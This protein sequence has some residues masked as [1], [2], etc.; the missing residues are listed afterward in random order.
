[1]LSIY[2]MVSYSWEYPNHPGGGPNVHGPEDTA[3][4]LSF[5]QEFRKDPVGKN[6]ILTAATYIAPFNGPDGSPLP[7]MSGFAKVLDWIVVMNYDIWGSWSPSVGPN[8][9]LDDTCAPSGFQHGSATSA[10][11]KWT[12]AG[13]PR[14]Q[15]VLGVPGYGHSFKVSKD[16]AYDKKAPG[17]LA[18][19]PPFQTASQPA[20]DSW[21]SG[22]FNMWGLVRNGYLNEDGS[23]KDGISYRYDECSQ[24]VGVSFL[25]RF[26]FLML[27]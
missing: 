2:D 1:M 23:V 24:T 5:L 25:P 8:A 7:D 21:G 26:E 4:F 6:L 9:P 27:D 17:T 20:G 11:K 15:I 10:I 16:K 13:F 22:N 14:N 3:N 19:Y 18:S 12:A